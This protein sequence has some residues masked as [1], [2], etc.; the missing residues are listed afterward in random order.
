MAD[1]VVQ[2]GACRVD[3]QVARQ[4]DG[5]AA[6]CPACARTAPTEEAI[7]V[8]RCAL[9]AVVMRD[10]DETL[11]DIV[12]ASPKVGYQPSERYDWVLRGAG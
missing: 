3:V 10:L 9:I 7:R 11:R 5:F 1:Y 2:C 12:R 6:R 4:G 8:A